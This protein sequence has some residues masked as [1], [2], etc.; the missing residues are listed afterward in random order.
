MLKRDELTNPRSCMSKAAD[1]EP[2]FVLRAQDK[3]APAMVRIWAGAALASGTPQAKV[4]EALDL[5]NAMES[6]QS[7]HS[8][9]VPD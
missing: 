6:W 8:A 5:A 2:V 4:N 1:D 9:K 3:H 7:E